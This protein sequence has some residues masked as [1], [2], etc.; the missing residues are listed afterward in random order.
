MLQFGE[1]LTLGLCVVTATYLVWHRRQV[2][3]V[4]G[5]RPLVLPF[6]LIA[7]AFL[8]TVVEGVPGGADAARII[9]W[10]RSPQAVQ[11]AGWIGSLLNLFEHA[12]YLAAAVAL[13]LAVWRRRKRTEAAPS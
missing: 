5:L 2:A 11:R 12:A 4:P 7:A 9:F 8:A 13:A 6:L 1:L 10:E 3:E